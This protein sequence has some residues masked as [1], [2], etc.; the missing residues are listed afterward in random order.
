MWKTDPVMLSKELTA[1][2]WYS[3]IDSASRMCAAVIVITG[4]EPLLRQ[5][6]FD[7]IRYIRKKGIACH[8]CTNGALLNEITVNRLKDSGI[9]TVSVS[10]DS[11]TAEIHNEMRGIDCFDTVVKGI[12]LL[13]GAAPEIKIGINY[14]ITKRNF[15]NM[16]RMIS[17][18]ERLGVDQIKFDPIHTN[19]MHRQKPLSSFEGLIFNRNDLSELRFEVD[20]LINAASRTKLLTN[21]ITFL[22]GILSLY[23]GQPSILRCY[24]GYVSCAIDAFGRVSPCDN[25]DGDESLRNKPFEEVWKSRSFQQLRK[26]V[27]NCDS[28]CWDTTHTVINIRCSTWGFMQEFTQILKEICFYFC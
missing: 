9:N 8:L 15:R 21:S 17:F 25:F 1:Q 26:L 11:D 10:L 18:A 5:D 7:I 23:K 28:R 14:V 13:K 6:I 27:D 2:E 20:K 22:K 3:F 16:D 19:L 12:R 4:G 24:A